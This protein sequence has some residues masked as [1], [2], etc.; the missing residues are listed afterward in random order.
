MMTCD[1]MCR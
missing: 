1:G